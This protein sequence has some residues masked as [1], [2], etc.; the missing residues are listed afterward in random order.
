MT[1]GDLDVYKTHKPNRENI[2]NKSY[3]GYSILLII[4]E[5][6]YYHIMG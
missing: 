2:I 1:F 3:A 4:Y 6:Q 5:Q